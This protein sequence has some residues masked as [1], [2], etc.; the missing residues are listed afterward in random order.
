M[1][2]LSLT[3]GLLPLLTVGTHGTSRAAVTAAD[4]QLRN[5]ADLVALC[6]ATASDP[7]ATAA[8][9]FCQG[10]GVGVTRTLEQ[11]DAA[12]PSRQ[13]MFCLPGHLTRDQAAAEFVRWASADPSRLAMPA[14][15]GVAAFLAAQYSCAHQ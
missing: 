1:R 4:F 8:V 6:S 14:T 11:Q 2:R 10:F 7:M 12:E 3:L 15:D 9:H 5:T 13:P